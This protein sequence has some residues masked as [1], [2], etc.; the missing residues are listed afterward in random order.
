MGASTF[1][2]KVAGM[3]VKGAG[4][5]VD[6]DVMAWNS[7]NKYLEPRTSGSVLAERTTYSVLSTTVDFTWPGDATFSANCFSLSVAASTTYLIEFFLIMTT[8]AT[9]DGYHLFLNGPASPT[10]LVYQWQGQTSTNKNS[11]GHSY[12]NTY[13]DTLSTD[14]A[15]ANSGNNPAYGWVLLVN[16]ANSGTVTLRFR[17]ETS[18][19][20]AHM[21]A[22]SIM[23]AR[24]I[25]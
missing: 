6:G 14:F 9:T 16:G 17:P 11:A 2:G 20:T 8:E 19:G 4:T 7:A 24:P 5:F 15:N 22:G 12:H 3:R 21:I 25:P 18:G 23:R 1:R 10:Q 13:L